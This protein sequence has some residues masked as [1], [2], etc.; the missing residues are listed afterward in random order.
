MKNNN[1]YF[2]ID[3]KGIGYLIFDFKKNDNVFDYNILIEFEELLKEISRNINIKVLILK[4]NKDNFILGYDLNELKKI[5]YFNE[6]KNL[7]DKVKSVLNKLSNLRFTTISLVNGKCLGIGVEIFL[8]TDY[9]I[10]SEKSYLQLYENFFKL[11]ALGGINILLP[12]IIGLENSIKFLLGEKIYPEKAIK[13]RLIQE[14]IPN[15]SIDYLPYKIALNYCN[16][17]KYISENFHSLKDVVIEETNLGQKYLLNKFENN[18]NKKFIEFIINSYNL[19]I[20]KALEEDSLFFAQLCE[21]KSPKNIIDFYFIEEKQFIKT[22]HEIKKIAIINIDTLN[23]SFYIDI[24]KNNF[25]VRLI[26]DYNKIS[27][28]QKD[29]SNIFGKKNLINKLSYSEDCS[30]LKSS[31]LIFLSDINSIN[32]IDIDDYNLVL[33]N[34]IQNLSKDEIITNYKYPKLIFPIS[35]NNNLIEIII[36]NNSLEKNINKVISFFK[37][38]NKKTII[39]NNFFVKKILISYLEEILSLYQ[40]N[41]NPY[42][43]DLIVKN[44]GFKNSP[45]EILKKSNFLGK[46]LNIIYNKKDYKEI[47]SIDIIKNRIV[48]SILKASIECLENRFVDSY[49]IIDLALVYGLG[50]P[51][52]LGGIFKYIDDMTIEE[53]VKNFEYLN[54]RYGDRFTTPNLLLKMKD[55]KETFYK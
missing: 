29:L 19:P 34:N 24:I 50:F 31:D 27:F 53:T 36:N 2:N 52:H 47:E 26:D 20:D 46:E 30:Y 10:M 14:I 32:K 33:F 22:T 4:S 45:L 35:I 28:L 17:S 13:L 1:I 11:S 25:N 38:L 12:R 55:N 6:A 40:E 18:N 9:R 37:C 16:K 41:Y 48:F 23:K 54:K 15:Y 21:S 3:E 49:Q 42:E 43:V 39:C 8:S 51:I 44:F 5:E 7:S